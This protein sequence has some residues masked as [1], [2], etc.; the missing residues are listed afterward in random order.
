MSFVTCKL[1]AQTGNQMFMIAATIAHALKHGVEYKIPSEGHSPELRTMPFPHLP[2]WSPADGLGAPYVESQEQFGLYHEMPYWPKMR[3]HGYFQNE[4]YFC[5]YRQEILAAFKIPYEPVSECSIHIRRT[6]YLKHPTKH[7]VV[8][9]EYIDQAIDHILLTT[10]CS[11]FKVFSDD[12]EWCIDAFKERFGSFGVE[13]F[14][15]MERGDTLAD[16]SKMS[17]CSH[18]II[19]NSTYSWWGAWL[20]QNGR[21]V[22]VCPKEWFG[23]GNA[24]LN[25]SQI[26]PPQWI[27]V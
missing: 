15:F 12:I 20:C 13:H 7:P 1:W 6:D 9:M 2:V 23:P 4:K 10:T 27:R 17:S 14:T 16:L 11:R 22:V 5:D 18:H 26:C 21:K 25:S 24:Q 19:A 8:T 3:L